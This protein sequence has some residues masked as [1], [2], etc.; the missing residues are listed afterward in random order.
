MFWI[1]SESWSQVW[2]KWTDVSARKDEEGVRAGKAVLGKGGRGMFSE[3]DSRQLDEKLLPPCYWSPGPDAWLQG[4]L[5]ARF[6]HSPLDRTG[7]GGKQEISLNGAV[8]GRQSELQHLQPTLPGPMLLERVF[9][10]CHSTK[11]LADRLAE[12]RFI[13][14]FEEDNFL[15]QISILGLQGV[16]KA[17]IRRQ[18]GQNAEN[19]GL[20]RAV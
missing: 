16:Q 19:V 17:F 13:Q 1:P 3:V 11:T 7:N 8:L 9:I 6:H 5:L 4:F 12:N 20:A 10:I 2:G 15:Y 18:M 14:G